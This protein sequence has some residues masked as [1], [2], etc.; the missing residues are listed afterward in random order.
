MN[1]VDVPERWAERH[2]VDPHDVVVSVSRE[3]LVG[4]ANALGEALQAVD[5]WEFDTRVGLLPDDA[6]SLRDQISDIL[7]TT[8]RPE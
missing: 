3:Q 7:R 6:R 2:G 8:A 5:D 4:C 1:I